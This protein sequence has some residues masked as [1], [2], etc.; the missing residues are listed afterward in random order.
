MMLVPLSIEGPKRA[1]HHCCRNFKSAVLAGPHLA[2]IR[3]PRLGMLD[4]KDMAATET[5]SPEAPPRDEDGGL[6]RDF[7]EQVQTAIEAQDSATLTDL[8]GELHQADV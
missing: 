1:C 3:S 5:R 7:V 2:A 4:Q 6:R 8:I